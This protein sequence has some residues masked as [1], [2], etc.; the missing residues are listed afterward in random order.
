MPQIPEDVIAHE[1]FID[2]VIVPAINNGDDNANRAD[3]SRPSP[4]TEHTISRNFRGQH[5][6]VKKNAPKIIKLLS[7]SD[8]RVKRSTAFE[9]TRGAEMMQ[10]SAVTM[11]SDSSTRRSSDFTETPGL[12]Q[13]VSKSETNLT[14]ENANLFNTMQTLT[15]SENVSNNLTAGTVTATETT[16][17]SSV[18]QNNSESNP[19][20]CPLRIYT[21]GSGVITGSKIYGLLKKPCPDNKPSEHDQ[22]Y[23][24]HILQRIQEFLAKSVHFT[25]QLLSKIS[26]IVSNL[27]NCFL[28]E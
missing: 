17:K 14:S 1:S 8:V 6:V 26:E 15:P 22:D 28:I 20:D 4:V 19:N 12:S 10:N 5:E 7:T 21:A 9:S 25:S 27:F 18:N 2:D 13:N 24:R 16:T 23:V 11:T 3:G